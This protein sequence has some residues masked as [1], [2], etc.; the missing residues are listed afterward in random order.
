MMISKPAEE[1]EEKMIVEV[2][3][4]EIH[5][6]LDDMDEDQFVFDETDFDFDAFIRSYATNKV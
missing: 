5:D 4:M 1:D 2:A 3:G 6:N